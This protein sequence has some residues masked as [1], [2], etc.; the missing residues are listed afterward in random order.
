LER[1]VQERTAELESQYA[2]LDAILDSA[3][4]G[5]I[6]ADEEGGVVRANP[7]AQAWLAQTLSP[8]EAARLR[9]AVRDLARQAEKRPETTLELTGLDLE[10]NVAPVATPSLS[11][12]ASGGNWGGA[13]IGIHDVSHLKALDRMKDHFVTNVSH[14]LRTP[15]TTIKLYAYL[16]QQHP[17]KWEQYLD[18]LVQEADHQA[19]LVEDILQISRID[20]GRLEMDPRPTSLDELAQAVIVSRS[21]LAQEQ[22]LTLE[23]RPTPPHLGPVALVDSDRMTQVLN[24]LVENAICYTP[25]GGSVTL[26]T[27][28]EEAQGRVWAT[29]TVEDTGTGI[30]EDELPYLFNRFFRGVRPRSMQS[31]GTGLGLAIVKEIVELHGGRVTVE[32]QVDVGSAFTVWLPLSGQ[33]KIAD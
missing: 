10:L 22:E 20:A 2:W 24:N 9:E 27:G 29:V 30:P 4:D 25:E 13:V 31:S 1:R 17:E 11:L 32:S 12:P 8:E 23:Y 14:E 6:V 26:S 7:V 3:T 18:T 5:I 21:V 33:D 16:M 28:T 15:I 19:Q